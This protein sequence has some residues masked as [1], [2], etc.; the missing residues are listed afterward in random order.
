MAQHHGWSLDELDSA[1]PFE[2]QIYIGLLM[3]HLKE[4]EEKRRRAQQ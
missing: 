1:I 2:R 3:K 4:L